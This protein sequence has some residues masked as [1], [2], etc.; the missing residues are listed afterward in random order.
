MGE[1]PNIVPVR[2]QDFPQGSTV[3]QG[4]G[5]TVAR[6]MP[7]DWVP[8]VLTVPENNTGFLHDN[9]FLH[10]LVHVTKY[11]EFVQPFG[12]PDNSGE[13]L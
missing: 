13:G 2:P 4:A 11:D 5:S 6:Y 1:T 8:M 10:R 7:K 12:L 3:R 9:P